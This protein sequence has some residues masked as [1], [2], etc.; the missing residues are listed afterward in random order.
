VTVHIL[1]GPPRS[2]K[3]ERMLGQF[4]TRFTV[5]PESVLWLAPTVRAVEAIRG[6][7]PVAD[8]VRAPLHTF[9]EML[10]SIIKANAPATR[11]LTAAQRRLLAEELVAALSTRGRLAHFSGVADTR[12]FTD[13]VLGLLTDL[14]RNAIPVEWFTKASNG[15]GPKERQCAQLYAQ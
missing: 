7:L 2:G 12:G 10:Q 3:T 11:L 6:R 15:A 14:Q 5:A 4:R 1:C 9:H 8:G 13:G